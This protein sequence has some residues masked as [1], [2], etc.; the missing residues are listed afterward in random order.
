VGHYAGLLA[1]YMGLSE[2]RVELISEAGRLHDIGKVGMPDSIL[3]KPSGLSAEEILTMQRHPTVGGDL[4]DAL[5]MVGCVKNGV[6]YHHERWDG[7]GYPHRLKGPDIP[8]E[9]RI[10]SVVDAYDAM[11]ST[12]PYRSSLGHQAA[13]R[14]LKSSAGSQLDPEV[15]G[16]FLDMVKDFDLAQTEGIKFNLYRRDG[17]RGEFRPG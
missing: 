10:I 13:I 11:T 15:V 1:R 17:P 12:R 6:I 5:E 9:T 16:V 8:L 7:S 14:E 3:K 2:D 4:L